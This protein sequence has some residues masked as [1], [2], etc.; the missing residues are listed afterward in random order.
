MKCGR[1][2]DGILAFEYLVY[3]NGNAVAKFFEA[4]CVVALKREETRLMKQFTSLH[5]T[6]FT[7]HFV[8]L[9]TCTIV[10]HFEKHVPPKGAHGK[11]KIVINFEIK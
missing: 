6:H 3:Y 2:R 1:I 7:S 4:Q 11:N 9:G 5:N 10:T 8:T